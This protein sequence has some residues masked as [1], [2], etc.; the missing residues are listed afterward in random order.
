MRARPRPD[1]DR[2]RS[3]PSGCTPHRGTIL[4]VS[5]ASRCAFR[6]RRRV[7]GVHQ[8]ALA[9]V[10]AWYALPRLEARYLKVSPGLHPTHRPES[11]STDP[12]THAK[13]TGVAMHRKAWA[14]A[15]IV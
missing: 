2:L 14:H 15:G 12:H 6:S 13:P 7:R 10:R 1:P 4:L 5:A 3:A 11:S 9:S 8:T